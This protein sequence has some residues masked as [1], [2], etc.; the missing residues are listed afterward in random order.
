MAVPGSRWESRQCF[1]VGVL[2]GPLVLV[3][4]QAVYALRH[5]RRHATA[6][7]CQTLKNTARGRQLQACMQCVQESKNVESQ[8][9]VSATITPAARGSSMMGQHRWKPR[10][11]PGLSAAKAG[12]TTRMGTMTLE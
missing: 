12:G 7:G 1:E 2:P 3:T 8:M 4:G 6:S 5:G 11:F 9:L 10:C